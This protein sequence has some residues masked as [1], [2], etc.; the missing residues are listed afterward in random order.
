MSKEIG[1]RIKRLRL[2]AGLNQQKVSDKLDITPGAFAKIERG[3]TD[4]SAS[5]LFE[6]ASIFKVDVMNLLKDE[7][8]KETPVK[9]DSSIAKQDF[10]NLIK[11]VNTLSKEFEKFKASMIAQNTKTRKK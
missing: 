9:K 5:R 6:I 2:L 3:E 8:P 11:Q 7:V 1:A 4:P 10:D